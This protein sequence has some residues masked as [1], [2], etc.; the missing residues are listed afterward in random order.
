MA[1]AGLGA[2]LLIANEVVDPRRLAALAALGDDG[3]VTVAVDSEATID[4]AAAPAMRGAS[5]TSTSACRA[6]AA[7]RR[8]PAGSPT[9]RPRRASRCAA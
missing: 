2:D 3:R 4:A 6:A 5:S 1:A 9:T 7:T 8:T